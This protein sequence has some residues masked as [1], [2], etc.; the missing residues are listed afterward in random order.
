MKLGLQG[1]HSG[2]APLRATGICVLGSNAGISGHCGLVRM[3]IFHA[4]V[5]GG[6]VTWYAWIPVILLSCA[7][8]RMDLLTSQFICKGGILDKRARLQ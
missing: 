4:G 8:V 5:R 6:E 3:L 2:R 1:C 7:G